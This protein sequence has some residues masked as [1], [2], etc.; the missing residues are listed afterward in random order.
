[1]DNIRWYNTT[2]I[3][4]DIGVLYHILSENKELS[5]DFIKQNDSHHVLFS[6]FTQRGIENTAAILE[7]PWVVF[8]N[9]A[10]TT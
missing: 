7:W 9:I 3:T 10:N 4:S 1:M 6:E 5:K 2:Y 8:R